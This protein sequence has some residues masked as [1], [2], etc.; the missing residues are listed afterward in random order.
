MSE[1]QYYE[2]LALDRPLN[3]SEKAYVQSLSSRVELTSTQ[4]KFVYNYGDFRGNPQELL[5]KC[6][7]IMLY[8]ASWG[9]RQLIFRFPKSLVN[10]DVFEP[11]CLED[12]ITV[13]TTKKSVILDINISDE[14]MSHWIDSGEGYLSDMVSLRNNLLQ[15]DYRCLYLAWLKAATI[16]F[17]PESADCIEPP[18]PANLDDLPNSLLVLVDFLEIEQDLMTAA[19]MASE[20]QEEEEDSLEDLIP[21]LS[22]REKNDFLVRLLN[23]ESHL[24]IQLNHRLRELSGKK[25]VHVNYDAPRRTLLELLKLAEGKTTQRAEKERELKR[26]AKIQKLQALAKKKDKVWEQVFELITLKQSKPYDQAVA[27]LVDLR[28]LAEYQGK[29]EEF[30]ASIQQMQK[31]YSS[32]PGLISRLQKVGLLRK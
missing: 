27:H 13:A 22:D 18:V 30:Q 21:N 15:G 31:D 3:A 20:S 26:Q 29:L 2:F 19:A 4:A 14:E 1:Y 28:D 17:D 6:F 23:G 11:Y 25:E 7:D 9:S 16:D 12:R 5:E 10:A 8:M 24:E 32:R